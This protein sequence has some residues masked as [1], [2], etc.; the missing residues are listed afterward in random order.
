[1]AEFISTLMGIP[2]RPVQPTLPG[3][4]DFGLRDFE[5]NM[6]YGTLAQNIAATSTA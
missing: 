1:M 3:Q 2:P 5:V 4:D 6:P